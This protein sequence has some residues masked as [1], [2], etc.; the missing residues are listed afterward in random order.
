MIKRYSDL[1]ANERTYLAWLRTGIAII[2]FGFLIERFDIIMRNVGKAV[3]DVQGLDI[4]DGGREAGLVLVSVGL[5][6]MAIATG[7]FIATRKRIED[8][9][10][11][12]YRT[13]P[14]VVLGVVLI[15]MGFFILAY[16]G[17]LVFS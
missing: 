5:L 15:L 17:R 6:V 2:A 8:E 14:I 13:A 11:K 12:S 1:A 9:E 16:I 10:E 4:G 3:G 7:R